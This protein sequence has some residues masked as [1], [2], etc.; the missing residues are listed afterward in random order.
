MRRQSLWARPDP[1][2]EP[3]VSAT[4][5]DNRLV[6]LTLR[7]HN[8]QQVKNFKDIL[9]TDIIDLLKNSTQKTQAYDGYLNDLQSTI[10]TLTNKTQ[11]YTTLL[12]QANNQYSAARETKLS[13]DQA[14]ID[15]VPSL[16]WY[17]MLILDS[18]NAWANAEK[19]RIAISA[20]TLLLNQTKRYSELASLKQTLLQTNRDLIIANY[21]ILDQQILWQLQDIT[22][23]LQSLQLQN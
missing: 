15:T 17:D 8:T 3:F 18:Q 9:Q 7:L 5:T 11:E 16:Q 20:Y 13:R 19:Y 14:F 22:F 21:A 10:I 4:N 2:P 6:E 23:Q 12:A 1:T